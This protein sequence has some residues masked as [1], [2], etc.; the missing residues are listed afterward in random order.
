MAK[1][2]FKLIARIDSNAPLAVEPILRRLFPDSALGRE[3]PTTFTL[4]GE[5]DGESARALNRQ[6]LTSLRRAEKRTRLRAEWTSAS[7]TTERY[8]DYVLK[9]TFRV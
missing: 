5:V 3:G 8:F 2:H 4:A 9:K 1:R 7:G 6:L